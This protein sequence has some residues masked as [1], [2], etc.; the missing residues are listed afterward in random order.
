M[1]P[2]PLPLEPAPAPAETVVIMPDGAP[3]YLIGYRPP[4]RLKK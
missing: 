4:R 3:H 2:T 1:T